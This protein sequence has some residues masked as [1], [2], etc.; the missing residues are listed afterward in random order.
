M[1]TIGSNEITLKFINFINYVLEL[2]MSSI[3]NL[4]DKAILEMP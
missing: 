2:F 3:N 4:E 1:Y